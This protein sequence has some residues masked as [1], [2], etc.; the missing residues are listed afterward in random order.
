MKRYWVA[1]NIARK[2][3]NKVWKHTIQNNVPNCSS[4]RSSLSSSLRRHHCDHWVWHTS[5]ATYPTDTF[6]E[7]LSIKLSL[8]T[9]NMTIRSAKRVAKQ[10]LLFCCHWLPVQNWRGVASGR[11]LVGPEE[12]E[13]QVG[14]QLLATNSTSWDM[15]FLKHRKAAQLPDN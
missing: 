10:T 6:R 8:E 2:V 4:L 13:A 9:E 1:H 15:E 14:A 7:T 5:H 11:E 3:G 12:P